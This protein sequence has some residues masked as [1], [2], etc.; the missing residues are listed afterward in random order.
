MLSPELPLSYLGW[1]S[2][3]GRDAIVLYDDREFALASLDQLSEDV[4]IDGQLAPWIEQARLYVRSIVG[5]TGE[6]STIDDDENEIP[7][8]RIET[9]LTIGSENEDLLCVDPADGFSVWVFMP[10]E[11]GVVERLH[12]SLEEWLEEVE[13]VD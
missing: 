8:S 9:F 5:A 12:D 3:F 1:R 10:G 6:T 2:R 4:R 11:G 7:F 13:Q